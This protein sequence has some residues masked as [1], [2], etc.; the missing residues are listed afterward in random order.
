MIELLDFDGHG[1]RV[2]LDERGDPWFVAADICQLLG[3]ANTTQAINRVDSDDLCIREVIDS[4]GRRQNA[5]AVNEAGLYALIFQSR[6][7]EA[8]DFKKV[9]FSEVLPTLRKTGSYSV[10]PQSP[11]LDREDILIIALEETRRAKALEERVAELAPAAKAWEKMEAARGDFSVAEASKILG[12]DTAI[13]TGPNKLMGWMRD[14]GWIYARDNLPIQ[15]QV[16]CGR[17]T[18][19]TVQYLRG[20]TDAVSYSTR[21]TVKG[22][23]DLHNKLGGTDPLAVQSKLAL[24]VAS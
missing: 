21:V 15:A 8:L 5:N 17:L 14:N 23:K 6:R 16:N 2:E 22:L 18:T 24:V 13:K 11:E 19:K 20:E 3:L 12:R 10:E 4:L 1:Y 9:V 7:P